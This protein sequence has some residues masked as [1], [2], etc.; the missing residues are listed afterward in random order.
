MV[1]SLHS[2]KYSFIVLDPCVFF[3]FLEATADPEGARWHLLVPPDP[4]GST[5]FLFSMP[6]FPLTTFMHESV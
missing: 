5:L 1:S 4:L 6:H 3:F 2:N